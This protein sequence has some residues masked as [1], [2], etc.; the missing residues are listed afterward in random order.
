M[1]KLISKAAKQMDS[2]VI[3]E[4]FKVLSKPNMISFAGGAP[5]VSCLPHKLIKKLSNEV[6]NEFGPN[7]FQYGVTEGFSPLRKE[8]ARIVKDRKISVTYKNVGISTGAQSVIDAVSKILVDANDKIVVESPTFLAALKSFRT[9]HP[10]IFSV[11]I[12]NKGLDI[13]NLVEIAKNNEIKFVY[14]IPNFQNPTGHTMSLKTRQKLALAAKKYNFI[15]VE[16]DP[17]FD[18]RYEGKHLPSIY[19][20]ASNQTVYIGS[21]SKVFSPGMRLGYY[22]AG[23]RLFDL[24]T[25]SRQATEVHANLYA[26]AIAFKY[27]S[28][29]H[30]SK[31]IRMIR[32]E[33]DEKLSLMYNELKKVLPDGFF[34]KK[35]LGGMFLW[36]V[37]PKGFDDEKLYSMALNSNVAIILGRHFYALDSKGSMDTKTQEPAFRLNFTNVSKTDIKRGIKVLGNCIKSVDK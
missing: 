34:V 26:Q 24:I 13:D 14:T 3:R 2:S 20:M 18:L 19:S 35:P 4:L 36:V 30:M 28:E 31:Q 10:K 12:S 5:S 16:D 32:K 23:G 27:I 17:Y 15:I 21:L 8:I 11:K 29:G 33:Y 22:I 1:D 37:C 6:I 25:S 9:Y 7:I